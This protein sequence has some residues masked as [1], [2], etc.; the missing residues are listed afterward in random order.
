MRSPA[1]SKTKLILPAGHPQANVGTV[2][3]CI[4]RSTIGL[5]EYSIIEPYQHAFLTYRS[6]IPVLLVSG[7]RSWPV[8]ALQVTEEVRA[9]SATD[10][11]AL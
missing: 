10:Y 5:A 7:Q 2:D 4:A 11:T 8:H 6:P 1:S 9:V 3:L